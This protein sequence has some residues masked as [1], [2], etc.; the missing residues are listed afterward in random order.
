MRMGWTKKWLCLV[1][2]GLGAALTA[3][4]L[5]R[6][7]VEEG[8]SGTPSV[9]DRV[10]TEENSELGELIRIAVANRTNMSEQ[11]R[12]ETVRKVTQSYAQ[13]RLLDQQI[14]QLGRRIAAT[15]GPAE[16]RYELVLA[17]AELESK[18]TTELAN[19][20]EVMGVVP[21]FP[22]EK[23]PTRG[24][25]TWLDLNLVDERVYVIDYVK[26]PSGYFSDYWA[27]SRWRSAGLQSEGETL[28]YIRVRLADPSKL[29]IRIE[30]HYRAEKTSAAG[31]LRDKVISLAKETNSQMDT[32]VRTELS[33]WVGSGESPFYLRQG[34]IYTFYPAPVQR[35]DGGTKRLVS[36]LV[37][38]DELEQSILWRLTKP[39]N[40]P[41]TFRIEYD[42]ASALLAKQ[43]AE[44]AGAVAQRLGIAELVGAKEILVE[45]VPEAAFLGRWKALK[46][47]EIQEIDFQ[48]EGQ[49]RLTMTTGAQTN[50]SAPWTLATKEIFID[51]GRTIMW[52]GY[53]DTEGNLVMDK[54]AMWPQ[55]SW[56]GQ[57]VAMIVFA[58]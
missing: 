53:L 57:G 45:P 8:Q 41:L 12:F 52:R 24:L 1:C 6:T 20:R 46:E 18:R 13:I 54:A 22:F 30:I 10:Q 19:L 55:G 32:E 17:K 48:P 16:M 35:P 14:D 5:G 23:K 42:E 33:V 25:S 50:V 9:L 21:K 26:P 7:A 37:S 43:V 44:T 27:D 15:G 58:R 38:Q 2:L 4:G 11:E 49:A 31:D 56:S 47:G 34:K 36:G 39:K 40:V 28:D 51:M 3:V 29:P